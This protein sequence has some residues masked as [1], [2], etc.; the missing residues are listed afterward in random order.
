MGQAKTR[1]DIH[2]VEHG[3]FATR[4][5]A[6]DAI[7]RGLVNVD[8]HAAAKPGQSVSEGARI[9]LTGEPLPYVSRSALKLAHAL[10]HFDIDVSGRVALDLGASS[11]G[12]TQ[13][14]LEAGASHVTALDVGHGQLDPALAADARVTSLEKT[15]ARHLTPDQVPDT[16]D[17]IVCDVSFIGLRLALPPAL[18]LVKSGSLLIALIK[19]QFEVGRDGLGK[20]GVVRDEASH[21]QVCDDIGAWLQGTM[22]WQVDGIVASPIEGADGNR[23]FLIA[24]TKRAKADQ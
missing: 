11:G 5:R 10:A 6:R 8:G 14:L 16:P 2:L 1:L 7:L 19:P 24:A 20:G 3:H 22:N 4:A 18:A 17:I 21:R 13:V 12:F 23:E 15:N 9:E